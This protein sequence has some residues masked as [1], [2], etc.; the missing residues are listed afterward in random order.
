MRGSAR[1]PPPRRRAAPS[2]PRP[3]PLRRA[4]ISFCFGG[5]QRVEDIYAACEGSGGQWGIDAIALMSRWARRGARRRLPPTP[6]PQRLLHNFAARLEGLAPEAPPRPRARM[7]CR[8]GSPLSQKL[9]LEQLGRGAGMDLADCL[10]MENRMVRPL[11]HSTIGSTAQRPSPATSALLHFG[12][13]QVYRCVTN[14]GSDFY[15][16]V[17]AA[18]ISRSS[19]PIWA[20]ASLKDVSAGAE[21]PAGEA[22]RR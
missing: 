7:R 21:R 16:G 13:P 3:P 10:R 8:R 9:T 14:V 5:K 20:H 11:P 4:D 12:A 17:D 19:N 18:L 6:P 2:R 15:S 22:R 1:A